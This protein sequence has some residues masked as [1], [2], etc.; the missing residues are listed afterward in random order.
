MVETRDSALPWPD[1]VPE[2]CDNWHLPNGLSAGR[3]LGILSEIPMSHCH[4]ASRGDVLTKGLG[5]ALCVVIAIVIVLC[6][7]LKRGQDR[8]GDTDL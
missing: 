6:K 2:T 8:L 7:S 3:F 4:L 5:I 1:T